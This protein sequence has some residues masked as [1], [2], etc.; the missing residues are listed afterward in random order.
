MKFCGLDVGSD[1]GE[2]PATPF[3]C[4]AR[5]DASIFGEAGAGTSNVAA[6]R[7]GGVGVEA[8]EGRD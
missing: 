2:L 1:V 8:E 5:S 4:C 6:F 7:R 3:G